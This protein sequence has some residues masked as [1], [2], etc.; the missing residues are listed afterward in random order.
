VANIPELIK[1]MHENCYLG[2]AFLWH[3]ERTK[4]LVYFV[5]LAAAVND[6]EGIAP[7]EQLRYL[8]LELDH[9]QD[10]ALTMFG[11]RQ[12]NWWRGCKGCLW[13]IEETAHRSSQISGL[14]CFGGWST[15]TEGLRRLMGGSESQCL[16]IN[17]IMAWLNYFFAHFN[18][19]SRLSSLVTLS[20]SYI[21]LEAARR[22]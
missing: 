22:I 9:H 11:S 13:R 15:R 3:I 6:R 2:H 17:K 14:C 19:G 16:D 1:G 4:V 7:W 10:V 18:P 8:V 5:D 20:S 21:S 12:Q